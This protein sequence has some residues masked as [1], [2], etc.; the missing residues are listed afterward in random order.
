MLAL[1]LALIIMLLVLALSWI[2]TCGIVYLIC[3]CF[4]LTFSWLVASGIW[5]LALLLKGIFS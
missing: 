5:L 3:L 1:F 2:V 4:N